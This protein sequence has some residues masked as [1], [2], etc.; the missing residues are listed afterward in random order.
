[1]LEEARK[2]SDKTIVLGNEE[3]LEIEDSAFD[4]FFTVTTLEFLDDY[5]MA[6]KEIARI[7][8]PSGKFLSM[9][10]NPKS[11][12]FKQEIQKT[13]DY[14]KIKHTNL[15]ELEITSHNFIKSLM[16]ITF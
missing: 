14:K 7:T 5:Q 8:K 9:I 16:K 3:H 2:R 4:A 1:M 10:L 15:K 11:E 6:V 12:Y 13:V